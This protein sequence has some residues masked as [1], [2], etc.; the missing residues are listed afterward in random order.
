MLDY[1]SELI[2]DGNT[3]APFVYKRRSFEHEREVRSVLREE[4]V[5][6]GTNAVDW[7]LD[8]PEGI[9]VPVALDRLINTIYV[10]PASQP[11]LLELVKSVV[12]KFGLHKDVVRSALDAEPLF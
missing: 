7:S 5:N 1:Q 6:S 4:P 2:P 8:T 9:N 3:L 12:T 10:S 11:W